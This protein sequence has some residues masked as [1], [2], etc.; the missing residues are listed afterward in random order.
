MKKTTDFTIAGVS[1]ALGE[2]KKIEMP[3]GR[4][5]TDN[6]VSMPVYVKRSKR[7]GPTRFI[8]AAIHGDELNGIEIIERLINWRSF[9]SLRGTLIAVPTVNVY[10]VINHSR[11]LPDRQ[12]GRASCRERV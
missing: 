3:I 11:Y 1:V 10:G 8:S 2:S 5:Y 7:P 9:N 6:I 12:I 4:L